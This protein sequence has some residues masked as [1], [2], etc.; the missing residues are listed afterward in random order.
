VGTL[1]RRELADQKVN[2]HNLY[3]KAE[4]IEEHLQHVSVPAIESIKAADMALP[5]QP[6]NYGDTPREPH[7]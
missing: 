6:S 2:V 1:S 4:G 7:V 5:G 3:R